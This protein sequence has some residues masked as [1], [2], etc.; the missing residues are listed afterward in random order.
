M[1][2]RW[3]FLLITY[4]AALH[5]I[6]AVIVL[7]PAWIGTIAEHVGL[8][9]RDAFYQEKLAGHLLGDASVPAGAA[10]FI[11]DSQIQGLDVTSVVPLAVNYGIGG[12]TTAGV[13]RRMPLYDSLTRAGVVVLEVGSNDLATASPSEILANYRKILAMIPPA[14]AIIVSAILPVSAAKSGERPGRFSRNQAINEINRSLA[15]ICAGRTGCLFVDV[16]KLADAAGDLAPA[17]DLGDGLHLSREGYRAWSGLLSGALTS[18]G[19]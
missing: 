7:R 12:D 15:E 19:H 2:P 1:T 5:G 13:L 3:K 17:F 6:V 11:G 14:A 10:I 9:S 16:D 18:N 4:V 8:K